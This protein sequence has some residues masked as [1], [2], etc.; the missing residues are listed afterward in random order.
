MKAGGENKAYFYTVAEAEEG[1][2]KVPPSNGQ[3]VDCSLR[4]RQVI[5]RVLRYGSPGV[6]NEVY[7]AGKRILVIYLRHRACH[8]KVQ[9]GASPHC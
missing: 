3:E 7:A 1:M 6:A 5:G 2:T 9:D 8:Q 4:S